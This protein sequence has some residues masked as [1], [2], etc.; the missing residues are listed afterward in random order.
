MIRMISVC[1]LKPHSLRLVYHRRAIVQCK[2]TGSV[3]RQTMFRVLDDKRQN[4]VLVVFLSTGLFIYTAL[5]T[6][7]QLIERPVS[8]SK[9][10]N[11]CGYTSDSLTVLSHQKWNYLKAYSTSIYKWSK[12]DG[13]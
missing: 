1:D 7:H 5:C 12:N 3:E 11:M 6:K 8:G 9:A 10:M 4:A 2:A 13:Q